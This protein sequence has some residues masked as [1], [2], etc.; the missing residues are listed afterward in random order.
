MD[1]IFDISNITANL[2]SIP[3]NQA[4]F[5][6]SKAR[7]MQIFPPNAFVI[8]AAVFGALTISKSYFDTVQTAAQ[9]SPR[10]IVFMY[11]LSA[12]GL[13]LALASIANIV[14]DG[15]YISADGSTHQAFLIVPQIQIMRWSFILG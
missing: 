6:E 14:G 1:V 9:I 10:L 3:E 5:D 12:W 7:L 4:T 11:T 13:S 8:I 15:Q 2:A